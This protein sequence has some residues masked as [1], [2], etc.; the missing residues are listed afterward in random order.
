MGMSAPAL[1]IA[2]AAMLAPRGG[3]AAHPD[4]RAAA[5]PAGDVTWTAGGRY[6]FAGR[7][8][9]LPFAPDGVGVGPD[10]FV[11]LAGRDVAPGAPVVA[12]IGRGGEARAV[13]GLDDLVGSEAAGAFWRPDGGVAWRVD[14][15][16][17]GDRL[18][19]VPDAPAEPVAISLGD[20]LVENPQPGVFVDRMLQGDLW[21][22]RRLRALELAA[23]GPRTATFDRALRRVV[24]EQGAP[25]VLR[26]RAAALLAEVGDPTGRSLVLL[27]ARSPAASGS[28]RLSSEHQLVL[29]APSEPCEA[30][31]P[32]AMALPF[33][34]GAARSYA[35]RLLPVQL[36]ADSLPLLRRL[37][38]SSEEQDRRDAALALGC[39]A[40]RQ[41]ELGSRLA[42]RPAARPAPRPGGLAAV[43]SAQDVGDRLRRLLLALVPIAL[44][45]LAGRRR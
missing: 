20:G 21:F 32:A 40:R 35:I 31:P 45:A 9:E 27:T 42:E 24:T 6:R 43:G 7:V 37:L 19:I 10:A 11:A 34:E 44:L 18:V 16:I 5:G 41:P 14:W 28:A 13:L 30:P 39:L 23:R 1:A 33:D 17:A 22:G 4:W 8:G 3:Q 25:L 2:A 26:L 38:G 15:W 12:V 29:P 36:G